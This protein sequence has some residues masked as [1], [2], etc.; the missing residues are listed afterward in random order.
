MGKF[1]QSQTREETNMLT[2]LR[3]K[4]KQATVVQQQ[5]FIYLKYAA[6]CVN[7]DGIFHT[8]LNKQC[9]MCQSN[10]FIHLAKILNRKEG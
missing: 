10:N 5:F 6:L 4:K 9:P 1:I 8:L 3:K 7:C 2:L